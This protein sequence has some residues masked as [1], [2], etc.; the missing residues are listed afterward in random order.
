M[1]GCYRGGSLDAEASIELSTT[2]DPVKSNPLSKYHPKSM[3]TVLTTH[4]STLDTAYIQ[5]AHHPVMRTLTESQR[6]MHTGGQ[7]EGKGYASGLREEKQDE[8]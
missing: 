3:K 5:H 2:L 8:Q 6:L 4:V 1:S 7:E